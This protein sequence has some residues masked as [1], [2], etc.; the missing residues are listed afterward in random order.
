MTILKYW[1]QKHQVALA[2]WQNVYQ[3]PQKEKMMKEV[4]RGALYYRVKGLV[5]RISYRQLKNGLQR[6]QMGVINELLPF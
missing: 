5:R 6:K 1:N 2:D 3:F 4:Y